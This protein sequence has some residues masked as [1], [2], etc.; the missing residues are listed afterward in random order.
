MKFII[1]PFLLVLV[2]FLASCETK[3]D[4]VNID[5]N[6]S[7][8]AKDANVLTSA[9]GFLGYIVDT[10]LN[11]ASFLWA[12]YYTWG[13]GVSIGNEERYVAEPDDT[14]AYWERAYA[15]CLADLKFL[16]KS[17]DPGYAGVGKVLQAYVFQGLVDHYGDIP[18]SEAVRGEAADGAILTPAY[19][20][21]A[22]VYDGIIALLDEGRRDLE[23]TFTTTMGADDQVYG[24]DVAKWIK[25]A[26]SLH[27]RLLMRT[28][29]TSPKGDAVK[30]LVAGNN[31]IDSHSDIAAVPFNGASGNQNPMYARFEWGVGDFYFASNATLNVLEELGDPR[32]TAFYSVATTGGFANNLRGINQGT[33]DNEPF[34]APASDYSG[35][36]DLVYGPDMPVIL[37]SDWEVKFLRAEAAARY[38]T[39]DDEEAMLGAAVQSNFD[40]FGVGDASTYVANLNY[41]GSLDEKIDII[42][43]QK[44]ISLNGTQEDEGWIET[45]RFDRP[46]SRLFTD[47]IFQN[48]PLSVLPA[49]TFP[50]SWLYPASERSLNPKAPAQRVI[51]DKIFWDN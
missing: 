27:L 37:M 43:V 20:N 22:T 9:Q 47:G 7:P 13:I 44:W 8:T 14:D 41:G 33:I 4:D 16:A 34:T 23:N 18:F 12:Q 15:D 2:L 32:G 36:S 24:G 31:F 29:E 11:A 3:F 21:A 50:A 6:N 51:T 48:P 46:A 26:N 1:K 39:A 40:H 19:D 5:P 30:A 38:G 45:R 42:A 10:D 25:F 28:S 49:G 17:E 35:S